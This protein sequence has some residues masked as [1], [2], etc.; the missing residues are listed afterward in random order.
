MIIWLVSYPKSGNTWIRF[1]LNHLLYSEDKDLDINN[2]SI[3]QFPNRKHFLNINTNINDTNDFVENCISAQEY[4]NLDNKIKLFKTHHAFWKNGKYIFTNEN[5]TLGCIYIVRDPR[6]IVTSLKNHYFFSNYSKAVEFMKN[7]KQII[8]IKNT[9]KEEDVPHIISSWKNHFNSWKKFKKNYLLI[10]YEDLIN[11]GI[12]E[13]FKIA[14]YLEKITNFK[15]TEGDILEAISKC[16]FE[17]LKEKE[18]LF[19][20][21]ETP[22][23]ELGHK[24]KFFYLGKDNDWKKLL[25]DE[26]IKEIESNFNEEM[27]ELKYI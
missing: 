21:S 2:I 26:T 7:E 22:I 3:N 23:N 8:G 15:F 20:F 18:S 1:F 25:N 19:G 14:N 13:F 17:N 4:L 5:N 16:D 12:K 6:N 10:K 11:N 24:G 9:K 27:R